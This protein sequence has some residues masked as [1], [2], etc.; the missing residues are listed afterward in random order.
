M[1][2]ASV[3]AQTL[4]AGLTA[5]R[6]TGATLYFPTYLS[7]LARAYAELGKFNDAWRCIDEALTAVDATKER[8]LEA[9]INRVAGEIALR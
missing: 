9:E 2:K 5:T 6:S 7:S 4:S 3:A 8:M 1:G